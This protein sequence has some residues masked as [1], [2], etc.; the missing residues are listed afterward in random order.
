MRWRAAGYASEDSIL[1]GNVRILPDNHRI[2]YYYTAAA[3][4]LA[5]YSYRQRAELAKQ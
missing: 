1:R 4:I 2:R 5:E 3:A